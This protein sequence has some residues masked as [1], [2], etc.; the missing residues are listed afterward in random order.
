[1][2]ERFDM[3]LLKHSEKSINKIHFETSIVKKQDYVSICS[4]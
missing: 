2:A 4:S 3:L 1:M